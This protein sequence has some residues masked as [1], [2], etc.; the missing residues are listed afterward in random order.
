[1][2]CVTI[3]HT[4]K[5]TKYCLPADIH[6]NFFFKIGIH[7]KQISSYFARED[8]TKREKEQVL[9]DDDLDRELDELT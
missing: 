7:K 3:P 8:T 1:M 9:S 2:C 4:L 5:F 6:L